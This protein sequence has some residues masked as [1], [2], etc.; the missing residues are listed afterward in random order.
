MLRIQ[1]HRYGGP[2]V[3]RLEEIALPEPGA[4]QVRVRVKAAASNPADFK[5]RAGGLSLVSGTKF[6]RGLGHDFAGVVDAVGA[7]VTRHK[8]GDEV[9]GVSGIRQAGAF[10]D[11][12][13]I[14]EKSAFRKPTS[15]SFEVAAG[16][17]R[18]GEVGAGEVGVVEQPPAAVDA[19]RL[20]VAQEGA[21][22]AARAAQE[23]LV[24]CDGAV[25]VALLP[26]TP[27]GYAR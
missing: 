25:D 5:V 18:S 21:L 22:A 10:A 23:P 17:G 15:V 16:E 24:Q 13:L 20:G 19:G 11:Y 4:S 3:M 6:P 26:R 2:E 8:I 1:Y 9:F 12:L 7:R 27:R 14:A